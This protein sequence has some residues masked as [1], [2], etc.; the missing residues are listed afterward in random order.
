MKLHGTICEIITDGYERLIHLDV[1]APHRKFW[2]HLIQHEEYLE[3]GEK[4]AYLSVGQRV[5]VEVGIDL[6]NEYSVLAAPSSVPHTFM[7]PISESSHVRVEVT[8]MEVEDEYTLLCEVEELGGT[9]FVE[10]EE[11]V[12]VKTGVT[13]RVTGNLKAEL[14][15]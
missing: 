13:L 10:F 8:V 2:C 1:S 15:G 12:D 4:S 7:Q 14:C 9:I 6:V 3:A 5:T 11:K